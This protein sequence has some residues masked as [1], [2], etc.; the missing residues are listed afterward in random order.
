MRN[1]R[2]FAKLHIGVESIPREVHRENDAHIPY[3]SCSGRSHIG[4]GYFIKEALKL[5]PIPLA[6]ADNKFRVSP[7]R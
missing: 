5:G 6:V 3:P 4:P 7:R 2:E 1:A